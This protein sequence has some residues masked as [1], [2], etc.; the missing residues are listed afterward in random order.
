MEAVMADLMHCLQLYQM[1]YP[2]KYL[3]QTYINHAFD[4]Y[5]VLVF[6]ARNKDIP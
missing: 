4:F 6:I 1:I 2:Y 3:Y 5:Y